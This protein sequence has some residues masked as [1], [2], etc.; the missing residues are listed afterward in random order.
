MARPTL[1]ELADQLS[2]LLNEL[3]TAI[4][5]RASSG[6]ETSGPRDPLDRASGLLGTVMSAIRRL[7]GSAEPAPAARRVRSRRGRLRPGE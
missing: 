3:D 6:L 4:R 7:T 1:P 5:A 2:S